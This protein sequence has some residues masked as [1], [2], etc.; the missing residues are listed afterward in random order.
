MKHIIKY[1]CNFLS[2]TLYN[3]IEEGM[4]SDSSIMSKINQEDERG[5][6]LFRI[7]LFMILC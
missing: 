4:S 7:T 3:D 2:A 6:I 1:L 5:E